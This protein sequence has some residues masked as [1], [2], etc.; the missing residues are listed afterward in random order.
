MMSY[1]GVITIDVVLIRG[2]TTISNIIDPLG[3]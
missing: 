1:G 3:H 2:I